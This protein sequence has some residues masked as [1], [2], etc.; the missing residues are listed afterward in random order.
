MTFF[1]D[2]FDAS[3]TFDTIPELL[4]IAVSVIMC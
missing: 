4:R 1:M 2:V 3:S